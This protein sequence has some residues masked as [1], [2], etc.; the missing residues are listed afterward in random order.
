[1]D[2]GGGEVI[3]VLAH[4]DDVLRDLRERMPE[5]PQATVRMLLCS[6]FGTDLVRELRIDEMTSLD[7]I[8]AERHPLLSV[9]ESL[10][11]S[12][13]SLP[14]QSRLMSHVS[15]EDSLLRLFGGDEI[16]AMM[17]RVGLEAEEPFQSRMLARRIRSTQTKVETQA[18]GNVP[19]DSAEEWLEINYR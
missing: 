9:D 2:V 19:A 3:V 16:R 8:V 15:L 10:E 5:F 18:Y 17:S 7:I 4:F 1:M 13:D 6:E 14:C 12:A 11:Q